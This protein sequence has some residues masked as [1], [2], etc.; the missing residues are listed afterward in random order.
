MLS[1]PRS[2]RRYFTVKMVVAYVIRQK[3][4]DIFDSLD[5]LNHQM[6]ALR[7][8]RSPVQQTRRWAKSGC[9]K[10]PESGQFEG[11]DQV[12]M[13]IDSSCLQST[14][15]VSERSRRSSRRSSVCSSSSSSSS[16]CS[17]TFGFDYEVSNSPSASRRSLSTN[18]RNSTSDLDDDESVISFG[19]SSTP[20]QA[21]EAL[22]QS[23]SSGRM[24]PVESIT[25]SAAMGP[26][27]KQVSFRSTVTLRL[28]ENVSDFSENEQTSLWYTQDELSHIKREA[29]HL[30][31]Y[32]K[33]NKLNPKDFPELRGLHMT[34]KH[35]R[36]AQSSMARKR[37]VE[38]QQNCSSSTAAMGSG[39]EILSEMYKT[40]SFLAL[41]IALE[42]GNEDAAAAASRPVSCF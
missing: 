38:E 32:A 1:F 33:A 39:Q 20:T 2:A 26:P 24:S 28:I 19:E 30:L 34:K 23:P 31:K 5:D 18:S 29:R 13:N 11:P 3:D 14:N 6:T 16:I 10:L 25:T 8:S 9:S 17:K 42:V 36:R 22:A 37:V 21:T 7:L 15:R 27:I 35:M 40:L 4:L 12:R 41:Q